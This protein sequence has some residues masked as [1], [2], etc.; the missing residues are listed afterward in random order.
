M[1]GFVTLAL[2]LVMASPLHEASGTTPET[3]RIPQNNTTAMHKRYCLTLDLRNDPALISQYKKVHTKEGI[4][5]E[6]PRGI[7]E[8][9]ISDMEIYRWGNRMF[10][11]VEAPLGWDYDR[12]MERLGTLE[13][14]AEWSDYVWQ[15]QQYV[16]WSKNGEKWMQMEKVFS[17]NPQGK[18]ESPATG[19]SEPS[20]TTPTQRFCATLDLKNNPGLIAEYRK[21]HAEDHWPVISDG[22]RSVGILDMQI[23]LIGNRMFMI[24]ETRPGFD[25]D[26]DMKKLSTLEKQQDWETLMH[27]YQQA[28]PGDKEIKWERMEKVFDLD[29]DF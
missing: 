25:W 12:E 7:K 26:R 21:Y 14:Q 18:K 4:W 11:I 22:I 2:M 5:P 20:Y 29:R 13:K 8:V 27:Q 24:A 19:Y 28:L 9:G 17:L 10:M 1:K 16:P 15:F 3:P 23:Y 6:I